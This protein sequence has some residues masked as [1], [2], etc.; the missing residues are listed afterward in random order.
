MFDLRFNYPIGIDIGKH[1][2]YAAQFKETGQALMVRELMH[3]ELDGEAQGIPE[4]NDAMISLLREVSGNKRFLGRRAVVR[5]P[6]ED[7][8]S[9]PIRFQV[10]KGETL[11]EAILGES[12][13]YLPFPIEEA[14]LDYPSIVSLSSGDADEYKAIIVAI[15]RDFMKQRL[16]MLK[17]A[18]LTV[19]AVDFGVSSLIRLHNRLYDVSQDPIILCKI[20][21]TRSSVSIVTKESIL[22]QHDIPWGIQ[23]LFRKIQTNL[24]HFN[25][26]DKAKLILKKYG[27]LYEDHQGRNNGKD[28]TEDSA[29]DKMCRVLYQIISPHIEEL[30][31]E[32][33]KIIGYVRAEAGVTLFEGIYMYGTATLI[34]HLDHYLEKRLNI[35]TSIINPMKKVALSDGVFLP[36]I[37][38]GAP[39]ALALGLA[40]RKVTWL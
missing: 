20:G 15:R 7:T 13:K 18:G 30:V 35:P 36:D 33:H 4:T 23:T 19:E 32:F 11:E 37:S 39:F 6:L 29:T 2:I 16:H 12:K 22:A 34:H 28:L 1:N 40:M 17:E 24:E 27:L 14:I 31:H 9:F 5:L 3:R 10:G 8:F 21:H 25:E 38:E 26:K